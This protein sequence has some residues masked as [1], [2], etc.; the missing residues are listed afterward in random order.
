MSRVGKNPVA[1]PEGVTVDIQ[2]DKVVVKG[3]RN[4]ND[5]NLI[6]VLDP[7]LQDTPVAKS[8][9]SQK[10]KRKSGDKSGKS[11]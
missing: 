9:E 6:K 2:A 5:G 3:Q 10:E 11:S 7:N 4:L 1:I 8:K